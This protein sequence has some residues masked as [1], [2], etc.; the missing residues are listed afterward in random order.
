MKAELLLDMPRRAFKETVS[1][2]T[3]IDDPECHWLVRFGCAK[4][5]DDECRQA[6]PEWNEQRQIV[7]LAK[8]KKIA[9]G[10]AT[11]EKRY[12]AANSEGE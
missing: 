7:M 8:Y 11:G 4:P 2:G 9:K 1:K 10:M 6:V 3:V 12:D 5:A